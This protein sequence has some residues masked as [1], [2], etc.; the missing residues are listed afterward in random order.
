MKRLALLAAATT[1]VLAGCDTTS[2][3]S[4]AA[5]LSAADQDIAATVVAG[6]LADQSNGFAT[7]LNDLN[8]TMDRSGLSYSATMLGGDHGRGGGFGDRFW[9]PGDR[10]NGRVTYDSTS[11]TFTLVYDRT[12]SLRGFV[13][14]A[15]ANLVYQ[16][17]TAA[18]TA[19][20][21]PR[22]NRALVHKVTYTGD[23]EGTENGTS[24][25]RDSTGTRTAA[26]TVARAYTSHAA[27]TLDGL[28]TTAATF[29]GDQ[30]S[31]GTMTLTRTDS[32]PVTTTYEATLTSSDVTI[33][34]DSTTAPEA[35]VQGT[36]T[37]KVTTTIQRGSN[38]P[39]TKVSEGTITLDGKGGALMRFEGINGSYYRIDLRDG[40]RE[41]RRHG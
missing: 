26:G 9:R 8:G 32:L 6:V 2:T 13:R 29:A 40:T 21:D 15:K 41:R 31:S 11:G 16:Y 36:L 25:R 3:D 23:R 35:R 24:Y 12:D 38:T 34:R 33:S 5:V 20:A 37:Y 22:R 27:W 17:L 18:G 14:T 4:P 7:D 30:A 28:T 19:I 1:L 10:Q 39:V